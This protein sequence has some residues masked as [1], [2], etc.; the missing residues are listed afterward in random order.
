[1]RPWIRTVPV[2]TSLDTR[3]SEVGGSQPGNRVPSSEFRVRAVRDVS[4]VRRRARQINSAREASGRQERRIVVRC[5][6]LKSGFSSYSFLSAT[7]VYLA[8]LKR[9]NLLVAKCYS[10]D[11]QISDS[12]NRCAWASFCFS[13]V[14]VI[15]LSNVFR[16]VP[17]VFNDSEKW[18]SF[19]YMYRKY[20]SENSSWR[21][22]ALM[23]AR[24]TNSPDLTD[25]WKSRSFSY[26]CHNSGRLENAIVDLIMGHGWR[27]LMLV[28]KNVIRLS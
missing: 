6:R 9:R 23:Y 15:K 26:T 19:S 16:E 27:V 10:L 17:C 18:R 1:M 7:N 21:V 3:R 22:L 8:F 25:F 24:G 11:F 4:C 2:A 13:F 5:N 20:D 28:A 12:Q 14:H